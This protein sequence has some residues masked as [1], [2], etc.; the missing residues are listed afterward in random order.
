M[1]D[2]EQIES[3]PKTFGVGV[4]NYSIESFIRTICPQCFSSGNLSLADSG[5][6]IDGMLVSHG[7]KV[8]VRRLCPEHGESESLY[9][10]DL[11]LWRERKGWGTPT[12]Q[13][14]PDRRDNLQPFPQGYAHG[15]TASHAQHTCILLLNVADS[16]NLA[17]PVCYA[18]ADKESNRAEP[19]ISEIIHTVTTVIEREHGKLG[20]LMLSGGEPTV[21]DDIV[22]LLEELVPLSITRIMLNTN[23]L[24]L[25][26]D[27]RLQRALEQLRDR[28][29]VYLQFDGFREE[30][31]QK[32]RGDGNLAG[33]KEQVAGQLN[34]GGVFFTLVPTVVRG[35]NEDEI[36][37]V[38][39][40]GLGLPFCAGVA[41][42]PSYLSGRHPGLDPQDRVTPTGIMAGIK[43]QTGGLLAG[44]DFIPLPCSHS[45][46]CAIAY[47]VQ[48]V[49]KKWHSLVSLIGRDE[50]KNWLHL[51]G[52]TIT[53]D[54]LSPPVMELVQSGALSRLFSREFSSGSIEVARDVARLCTCIPGVSR[55]VGGFGE[56]FTGRRRANSKSA[57]HPGER[58]FRITI[59]QFM[60]AH[61]LNSHRLRQCCV[62]TGT[63]EDDP[64][65]YP[66]CWRFLMGRGA[67]FPANECAGSPCD[68]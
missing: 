65:R 63:F 50:L 14:T 51:V 48:D 54:E 37:N 41:I 47:L 36:G 43:H 2:A 62:H 22:E 1:S 64:R 45:D 9:E 17:C 46:C 67:D 23:G 29:E 35:I 58:T 21:R 5:N 66:K 20:V 39:E 24:R 40:H 6:W 49:G 44:S 26:R 60:D 56:F 38:I 7:G 3:Q 30:T 68:A 27:N 55:L 15:L 18:A 10:E 53:F 8:W 25:A 28:V 31:Y 59:K 11:E 13:V 57:A 61:T 33:L 34:E 42:Q 19:S 16:C 52:N 32:L 12:R 4:R